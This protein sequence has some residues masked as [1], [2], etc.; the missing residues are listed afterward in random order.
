MEEQQNSTG[1]NF[2]EFI[3]DTKETL[4]NPK[5]YFARM[6]LSGG[7][8]EPVIKVLIYG[9]II[10]VLNLIWSMTGMIFGG[11]SMLFGG[12]VGFMA[13]VGGIIGSLIGLFIGGVILLVISAIF[14]GNTDYE[15]NVR[16]VSA[17]YIIS[18][19]QAVFNFLDGVNLYL[20]AIV[21]IVISLWGLYITYIALT[22]RLKAQEKGTKILLIILGVLVII[23]SF[24]GIAA[25]KVSQSILKGAYS[26]ESYT[27]EDAMK[28]VEKMTGGQV[29]AEELKKG[30][31]E[32]KKL[33][34]QIE[35]SEAKAESGSEFVKPDEFPSV[36]FENVS[37]ALSDESKLNEEDFDKALQMFAA[38][39]AIDSASVAGYSE[40]EKNAYSDSIANVFGFENFDEAVNTNI[41]PMMLSAT[42]I[43]MFG[44]QSADN[45]PSEEMIKDFLSQNPVSLDD[46]KFTFNHWDKLSEIQKYVKDAN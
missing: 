22:E 9:V 3:K 20:S 39:A 10:G 24:T 19:I 34:E 15:A 30:M 26:E 14:K 33:G 28:M 12:G 4:T 46:L 31:E 35:K 23:T 44:N 40:E 45:K 38:L 16:V 2:N 41:K 32:A 42:I 8:G 5:A 1:F 37:D 21:G 43:T 11:G 29:K 7:F 13:L 25:K 18:V 17:L 27:P 36:L 6:P